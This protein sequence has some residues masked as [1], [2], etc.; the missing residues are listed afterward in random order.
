MPPVAMLVL[1]PPG[2][3]LA[4]AAV[5]VLCPSGAGDLI[6]ATLKAPAAVPPATPAVSTFVVARDADALSSTVG[7]AFAVATPGM[8]SG[9][10]ESSWIPSPPAKA[11]DVAP[12]SSEHEWRLQM[13]TW[14]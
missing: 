2:P 1:L 6:T 11:A 12:A 3:L 5:A 14:S 13:L 8:V 4:V 10:W 7:F 9:L